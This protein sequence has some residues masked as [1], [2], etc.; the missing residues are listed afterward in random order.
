MSR[1][2]DWEAEVSGDS[3]DDEE[4]DDED[5]CGDFIDDNPESE[6]EEEVRIRSRDKICDPDELANLQEGVYDDLEDD[7]EDEYS[8]EDEVVAVVMPPLPRPTTVP[9]LP[10]STPAPVLHPNAPPRAGAHPM[11]RASDMFQIT[12]FVAARRDPSPEK[13][14]R[15][16]NFMMNPK[17][18]PSTPAKSAKSRFNKK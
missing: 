18:R 10:R 15:N 11:K 5:D 3:D 4:E 17:P 13:D 16:W 9:P 6:V 1:F 2:V 8:S 14:H 12:R 7:L